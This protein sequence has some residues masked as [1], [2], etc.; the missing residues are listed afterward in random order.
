MFSRFRERLADT[1]TCSVRPWMQR[2]K[3]RSSDEA[4]LREAGLLE[5]PSG[6]AWD[7]IEDYLDQVCGRLP[8]LSYAERQQIREELRQHIEAMVD[9]YCELGEMREEA[10]SQAL[11]RFGRPQQVARSFFAAYWTSG[12]RRHQSASAAMRKGIGVYGM[13]GLLTVLGVATAVELLSLPPILNSS[14]VT[15][16]RQAFL[17]SIMFLV[18]A[19]AGWYM[20]ADIRTPRPALGSFFA[21][22]ALCGL[23]LPLTLLFIKSGP[24][25]VTALGCLNVLFFLWMPT[26][27]I[28]AAFSH[29]MARHC[30]S[31]RRGTEVA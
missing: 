15:L 9:A 5:T 29:R 17:P 14:L 6:Q 26:A 20:G 8:M 11:A 10:V 24:F 23:S 4:A 31:T 25:A 12:E 3:V 18:P 22:T 7:G 13:A 19:L 1:E 28:A 30:G 21:L 2:Q 27:V 16:A